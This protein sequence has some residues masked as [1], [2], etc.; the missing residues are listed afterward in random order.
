MAVHGGQPQLEVDLHEHGTIEPKI[1]RD[2][3]RRRGRERG[4]IAEPL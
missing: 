1:L 4:N 2:G 3:K